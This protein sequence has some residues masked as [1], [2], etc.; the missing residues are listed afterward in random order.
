MFF[1][2][3][4]QHSRLCIPG[5][6][7]RANQENMMIHRH[8]EM[9]FVIWYVAAVLYSRMLISDLVSLI[10]EIWTFFGLSVAQRAFVALTYQLSLIS[11]HETDCIAK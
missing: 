10:L 1:F 6:A 2:W 7:I 8:V 3:C 4:S 9:S 5:S 11:E